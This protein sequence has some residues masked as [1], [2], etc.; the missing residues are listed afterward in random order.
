MGE[1]F[2]KSDFAHII[3]TKGCIGSAIVL[4]N[5]VLSGAYGCAGEVEYVCHDFTDRY[6]CLKQA[7]MAIYSVVDV[8][9]IVFSGKEITQDDMYKLR[10]HID[11]KLADFRRPELVYIEDDN[12]LYMNGLNRI[13]IRFFEEL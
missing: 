7:M 5:R 1:S 2:C 6:L 11:T 4:N 12:S 9:I 8:P 10:E 13:M 3:W